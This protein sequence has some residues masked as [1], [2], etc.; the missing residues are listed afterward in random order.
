[1]R[2]IDGYDTLT[3]LGTGQFGNVVLVR[4]NSD[5]KLFAAKIPH[6]EDIAA[7]QAASQ[8][9]QLLMHLHHVNIVQFVEVVE[10]DSQLA[11]VMEYASGGDLEAFL[12]WQQESTGCLSEPAIM[13]IFIQIVLALQYLHE[14]RILH[15]DL[16]PKN[17]LLDGDGIVKLSDF[18]VSKL[19]KSS[20][21]LAQTTTGTPHYM[22]PELLEG[23]TYDYKSD[24]WSLGCVLYELA[25]FSPP[26]NGAA[27]GAVVGKI[28]HSKPPL[29]SELYS[30]QLRGLVTNLLEKDPSRR[31]SLSDILRSDL[32]QRHMQQLVSVATSHQPML[33]DQFA[34]RTIHHKVVTHLD[35]VSPLPNYQSTHNRGG[36]NH[37]HLMMH[38]SVAKSPI[39]TQSEADRARQLYFE[40]QA[41]AR[42]NKERFDQERS[43]TAVFLDFKDTAGPLERDVQAAVLKMQSIPEVTSPTSVMSGRVPPP[44]PGSLRLRVHSSLANYEELLN[45]ERRRIQLETRALQE[46]MRAMQATDL[47]LQH[48]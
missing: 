30:L 31:P 16:K 39:S 42:R 33:L 1:M 2:D 14:H 12:R 29:L 44:T 19:L 26:F 11:L 41:A 9:A 17:I 34:A 8:E 22:A 27:L 5:Q 48:D 37:D 32:V 3:V 20:L 38:N 15:R 10:N 46:R 45:A 21:D 7:R 18:G 47:S 23:G 13:R 35:P 40:N 28:L 36:G 24:V 6:G 43:C 4:R 25:A